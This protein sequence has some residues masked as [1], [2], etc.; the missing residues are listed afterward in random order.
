MRFPRNVR[1]FRGQLDPAPYAGV[2]FLL[3]ILMLLSSSLVFTPGVRINLPEAVNLPGADN[4]T[5]IVA[6]D[7]GGQ[8]YF[9]NQAIDRQQ[10]TSKL[11][12]AVVQTKEPVTLIIQADK[13]VKNEVVVQ[14]G[15]LARSVGIKEA[16]L[17]TRPPPM[18]SAGPAKL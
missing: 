13:N 18:P 10:L 6:V 2:F 11:S 4:P 16:L 3:A 9:R 8:L 17:A 15:L 5:V 7:E 12:E 1:I 14:L